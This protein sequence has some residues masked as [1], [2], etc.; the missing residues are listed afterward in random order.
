[1]NG[2]SGV[3]I[4]GVIIGAVLVIGLL[5]FAFGESLGIRGP[6][7]TTNVKVEA[8]RAPTPA[9]TPNK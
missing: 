4:L 8:P 3:G 9:P 2:D 5:F 1:M 7:T 6:S